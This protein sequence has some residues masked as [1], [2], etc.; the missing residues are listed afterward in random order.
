[1]DDSLEGKAGVGDLV[2]KVRKREQFWVAGQLTVNGFAGTEQEAAQ[3]ILDEFDRVCRRKFKENVSKSKK[4]LFTRRGSRLLIMKS[5]TEL[6][7]KSTK[8]CNLCL[9]E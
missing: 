7:V 3:R 4:M 5:H 1:M 2:V 9:C 6:E 8:E